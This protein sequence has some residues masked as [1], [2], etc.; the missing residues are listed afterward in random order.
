M[1]NNNGKFRI[2]LTGWKAYAVASIAG[3][4]VCLAIYGASVIGHKVVE[5][6]E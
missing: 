1:E 5:S 6:F 2:V 3:A 4:V